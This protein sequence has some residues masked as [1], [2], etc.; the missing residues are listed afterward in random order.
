MNENK[1]SGKADIYVQYRPTYPGAFIG[2]L[3]AEVGFAPA[4]RIADIGAGTG[5]FSRLLLEKGSRVFCVEP[6]ADM[7]RAARNGLGQFPDCEFVQASAENTGLPDK[8][9]DFVT[10]T[11][12]FHW[13]DRARFKHECQ[14]ILK[15]GGKVMLAWNS[16]DA[17]EEVTRENARINKLMCPKFAGFSGGSAEDPEAY[18][19]FFK[20]GRCEFRTF[21]NDL[22]FDREAFI[23]RCLSASYAPL[24]G[25]SAYE[26]YRA[27]IAELFEKYSR[28]GILPMGN[29]VRSYVGEV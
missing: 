12:A 21:R 23:G 26:E 13:F 2:Y 4:S 3:Y 5:I 28:D 1:F 14:R 19:D 6:N 9:V 7:L 17:D 29:I 16:R 15:D 22:R 10:A 18:A 27:K 24:P 11:Q 20:D 25:A 8:S